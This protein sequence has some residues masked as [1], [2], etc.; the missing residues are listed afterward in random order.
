MQKYAL[1]DLQGTL[2]KRMYILD[3]FMNH[4]KN[5]GVRYEGEDLVISECFTKVVEEYKRTNDY[6]WLAHT[7]HDVS[8]LTYKGKMPSDYLSDIDLFMTNQDEEISDWV[9]PWFYK[10]F[11][12]LKDEDYK[13]YIVSTDSKSFPEFVMNKLS[14]EGID[15]DGVFSSIY[16]TNEKGRFTGK[17]EYLCH[18]DEKINSVRKNLGDF[19]KEN[20]IAFGDSSG[21]LS[22][23]S[24]VGRGFLL[25]SEINPNTLDMNI[26]IV[27]HESILDKVLEYL[28]G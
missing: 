26:S 10:L 13:I 15:L 12:V 27:S 7:W 17:V 28:N 4:P 19:S 2:L 14:M 22:M 20:S 5:W 24:N 8:A 1:F 6:S 11:Q 18:G 23:L 3:F 16:E 25:N 21:D 9:S